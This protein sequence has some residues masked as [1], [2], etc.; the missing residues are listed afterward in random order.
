MDDRPSDAR[1]DLLA[2]PDGALR[3]VE[4]SPTQYDQ[5]ETAYHAV[6][7]WLADSDDPLLKSARIYAQG[8]VRL[9][10]S[11]R[12]LGADHFDVD[13]VCLLPA[14]HPSVHSAVKVSEIIGKRLAESGRYK[15]MLE[16]K[17]RCWRLNYAESSRFHMDITP[18][19]P[20]P[21]CSQQGILVPDRELRQL[22]PSNPEHYA[23]LFD[24]ASK[25]E[26]TFTDLVLDFAKA[27]AL[28]RAE[29]DPLPDPMQPRDM[30]RRIVQLLKRHR[31]LYFESTEGHPPISIILTTLAATSYGREALRTWP[32]PWAF[33]QTVL[34]RLPHYVE[35]SP[36]RYQVR[37][38]SALGENFAEKWNTEPQ[39]ATDF[40]K[41]HRLLVADVEAYQRSE[42]LDQRIPIMRDR[43]VGPETNAWH[44][45]RLSTIQRRR[46]DGTLARAPIT[47]GLLAAGHGTSIRANTFF[48]AAR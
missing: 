28:A 25:I 8:S 10:T 24:M 6:G 30:L 48:G 15:R 9:R 7:N 44:R 33:I 39:K 40:F 23:E 42:G 21:A 13:L 26:P 20:N 45:N 36:G 5:L 46:T 34:A 18:A 19:M 2:N 37:N 29:I 43:L 27:I 3:G 47:G 17:N 16:P 1:L 11:V 4:L 31:D 32:N 38:P 35:G 14:A 12:P 41:W 22:K